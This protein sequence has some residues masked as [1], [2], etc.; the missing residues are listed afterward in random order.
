MFP[1]APG[2]AIRPLGS[3]QEPRPAVAGWA[4]RGSVVT[5]GVWFFRLRE[6]YPANTPATAG[7]R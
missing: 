1:Q 5:T 3:R 4:E 2:G 6:T 7:R